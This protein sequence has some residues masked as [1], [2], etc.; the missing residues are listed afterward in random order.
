MIYLIFKYYIYIY[1]MNLNN[2][3]LMRIWG[4]NGLLGGLSVFSMLY[5]VHLIYDTYNLKYT[6]PQTNLLSSTYGHR[7]SIICLSFIS[8]YILEYV[9]PS[10]LTNIY[11]IL[12]LI[13]FNIIGIYLPE[14]YTKERHNMH[15]YSIIV[16]FASMYHILNVLNSMTDPSVE[17][18]KDA[19]KKLA[20]LERP[21]N[22]T[23][24]EWR[25]LQNKHMK[26]VNKWRKDNKEYFINIGENLEIHPFNKTHN[27]RTPT[28][29]DPRT[30]RSNN[31]CSRPS[32]TPMDINIQNVGS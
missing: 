17:I 1:I 24:N 4:Y 30:S 3:D 27:Y 5:S 22:L 11:L 6:Q 20:P 10:D 29:S 32:R 2:T 9:V 19:R 12:L 13:I 15:W 7:I 26:Y 18:A 8:F 23:P 16:L 28:M 25:R 31:V 14:E 21:P